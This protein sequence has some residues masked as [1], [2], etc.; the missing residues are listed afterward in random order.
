MHKTENTKG[1]EMKKFTHEKTN[2][3]FNCTLLYP[4]TECARGWDLF[5]IV[6]KIW[7]IKIF[8]WDRYQGKHFTNKEIYE[9][10][11]FLFKE[12]IWLIAL[13]GFAD[14]LILAYTVYSNLISCLNAKALCLTY[15]TAGIRMDLRRTLHAER[16]CRLF[17]NIIL[18]KHEIGV[19]SNQS[20]SYTYQ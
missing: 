9:Q 4:S 2:L 12:I 6:W 11:H 5:K 19:I 18:I 7:H 17:Q 3:L 14:T 13:H 8:C 1:L 15:I 20:T 10:I 16:Y